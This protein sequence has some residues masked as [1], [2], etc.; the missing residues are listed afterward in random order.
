MSTVIEGP[1]V[2]AFFLQK[3]LIAGLATGGVKG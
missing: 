2:I 3:S 1:A